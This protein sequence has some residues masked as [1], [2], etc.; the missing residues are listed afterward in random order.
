[1][2]IEI[3]L[4]PENKNAIVP[5]NYNDEIH[6]QLLEKIFLAAP[7]LAEVL[8][9]EYKDY[10][11]FSRI[12][13][14]EREIIPDKGIKVLSDDISLY[15]SS[16]LTEIIK[17]IAEGF[18][19]NPILKVGEATFSMADIKILREPKIRDG[20]LFS[21]LSPIVVRTAKFEDN[22]VKI[23]DLYPNNEGFQDKLRKIMLTKFSE[24]NGRFPED[25]DFHLDVI[26]FKPVRIKVG[27][28]YYRGSLMV[29]RYYGSK[30]IAKFGYE[31]GFGDKTSYGFG[32]VKVIDEEEGQ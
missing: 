6:D 26:K 9:T 21:T 20:T 10:F 22:K 19:S 15:V 13:I 25:T 7:D 27:K 17:A 16:S 12:M 8:Q 24:I 4:K 5:F 23:W 31:N 30:E 3:K 14:R 29:F 1:M 2:R 28:T 11:T 18:I 32:M